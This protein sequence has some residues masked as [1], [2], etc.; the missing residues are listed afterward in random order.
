MCILNVNVSNIPH[1]NLQTALWLVPVTSRPPQFETL[2][3]SQFQ[4]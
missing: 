1:P 2:K 3:E 4:T